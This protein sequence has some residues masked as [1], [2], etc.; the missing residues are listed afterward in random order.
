MTNIFAD[1]VLGLNETP[2][3]PKLLR[4]RSHQ[5]SAAAF[6]LAHEWIYYQ[7]SNPC[8]WWTC[9]GGTRALLA[10]QHKISR[11]TGQ[12][13]IKELHWSIILYNLHW[14][15]IYDLSVARHGDI[16]MTNIQRTSHDLKFVCHRLGLGLRTILISIASH[17][18]GQRAVFS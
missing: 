2:T 16:N 4:S 10:A 7:V 14:Y 12:W 15:Y 8:V 11:S 6:H 3:S 13:F 9:C 5:F 17:M 1:S 18:A